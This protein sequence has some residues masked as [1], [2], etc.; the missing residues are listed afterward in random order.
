MFPVSAWDVDGDLD[1]SVDVLDGSA[2]AT[3]EAVA[4]LERREPLE[5]ESHSVAGVSEGCSLLDKSDGLTF[6]L[7]MQLGPF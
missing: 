4:H 3:G 5:R 2:Y 7:S 6:G 1:G